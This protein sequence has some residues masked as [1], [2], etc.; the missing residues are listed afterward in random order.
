MK[1][2]QKSEMSIFLDAIRSSDPAVRN[3]SLDSCCAGLT[4]EQLIGACL[5][6]DQFRRT[7]TNLYERV[8]ALFFLHS[9]YRYQLPAQ[10]EADGRETGHIAFRG[11]EL[12]LARRFHES[13]D[14]FLEQLRT[15]GPTVTL[16]SALAEACHQL[17]FQTL[18]DQVRR[19]VRTVRGNQW[20]FRAG[21]PADLPLRI[22]PELLK[23]H[24]DHGRFPSL[25][26]CTA[27]RMDFT[28]SA[29]SDI[30]FLGMDFPEGAQVI[31]A[32]IDLAVRGRHEQP[33]PPIDCGLRIID[34]PVLRLVSI[35]LN[36]RADIEEVAEVFD[37][38]RDYLG[39]LKAAVIA[40]GLIP[41]GMEGWR[42]I[43]R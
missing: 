8:R 17:A 36:A 28:H 6:L 29:W 33:T 22:R 21:H 26:E 10:L 12:L 5:E 11:Y 37:F 27:V 34:E 13:I 40:A 3:Q 24:P 18:A 15:A 16:T 20:M 38:A 7:S 1:P 2:M 41:P 9:I 31:N 14:V 4:A 42:G 35:D 39:L 30:F 23:S 25:R 43:H 19:S 32:S